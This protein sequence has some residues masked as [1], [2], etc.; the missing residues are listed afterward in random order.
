MPEVQ[1]T[2]DI[3]GGISQI[4]KFYSVKKS[5]YKDLIEAA[6]KVGLL[7]HRKNFEV[8][9]KDF[10]VGICSIYNSSPKAPNSR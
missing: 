3:T 2:G 1:L 10:N 6:L 4:H 5:D 9:P 7:E 8:Y